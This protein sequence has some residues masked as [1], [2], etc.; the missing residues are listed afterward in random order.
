MTRTESAG[1]SG[2]RMVLGGWG[3]SSSG[4]TCSPSRNTS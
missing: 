4:Q 2:V 3:E 1:T